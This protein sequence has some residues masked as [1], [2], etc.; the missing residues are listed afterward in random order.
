MDESPGPA[1]VGQESIAAQSRAQQDAARG[2]LSQLL[3]QIEADKAK[4][5][6]QKL[7][8]QTDL[9]KVRNQLRISNSLANLQSMFEQFGEL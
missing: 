8:G 2:S 3:A 9:E 7:L 6:A 4:A 5:E 1:I